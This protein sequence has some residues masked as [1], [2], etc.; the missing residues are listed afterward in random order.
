[1]SRASASRRA[2]APRRLGGMPQDVR[3]SPDGKL[4]YV[5]DLRAGG[6][7]KVDGDPFK[8]VGFIRTGAGAHGVY[9]SR[10]GTQLYVSNRDAGSVS[11]I[12]LG[13]QRSSRSGGSRRRQ[14][15][16]G[17]C[18]GRRQGAVAVAVATTVTSMRSP[19]R[20]ADSWHASRSAPDRTGSAS[21]RSRAVT[22]LA[23]RTTCGRRLRA[24]AGAA[25]VGLLLCGCGAH[26][27]ASSALSQRGRETFA[28]D[29]SR[30]HTLTGRDSR[31]SGGDLAIARLSVPD[32]A[33]FVRVMPV[34]L[35]SAEVEA[36]AVYVHAARVQREGRACI[37]GTTRRPCP[38]RG[39]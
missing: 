23:T 5:A 34:K 6:V 12:S 24:L 10:D 32:I 9:P 11:V 30:C 13:A 31:A 14:P 3:V 22:R 29:C 35:S 18:L 33:S 16:H 7:W 17:R 21:G 39:G 8:V 38:A 37:S 4:F 20:R 2:P 25:V 19:P 26:N 1:M 15:R 28:S 36:V 27:R